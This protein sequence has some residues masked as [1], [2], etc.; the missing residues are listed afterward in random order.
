[1]YARICTK[2]DN[3]RLQYRIPYIKINIELKFKPL[4]TVL[5]HPAN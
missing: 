3:V 2:L 4:S 1:M 5:P